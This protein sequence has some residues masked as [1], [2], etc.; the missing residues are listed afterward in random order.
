ML[1]SRRGGGVLIALD[2]RGAGWSSADFARYLRQW[3]DLS[4]DCSFAVGGADGHGEEL[5]RAADVT[6]SLG[7]I[8]LPHLLARAVLCEQ[9]YRAVTLCIGHPYHRA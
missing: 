1:L 3:A 8:T 6:V 9:I 2:E 5:R 7:A 4:A